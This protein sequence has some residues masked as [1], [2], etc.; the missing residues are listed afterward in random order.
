MKERKKI[1][2]TTNI[3]TIIVDSKWVTTTEYKGTDLEEAKR[4]F[5]N[6]QNG[7]D[8]VVYFYVNN[9]VAV[10]GWQNQPFVI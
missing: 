9:E 3:Y 2:I 7:K 1:K 5:F 6:L 10:W 4:V 8:S